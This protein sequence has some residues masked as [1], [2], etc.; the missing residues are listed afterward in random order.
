MNDKKFRIGG[1]DG[2]SVPRLASKF[3]EITRGL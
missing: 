2:S 3:P 1:S